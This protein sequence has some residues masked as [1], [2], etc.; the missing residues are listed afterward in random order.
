MRLQDFIRDSL[1][2]ISGGVQEARSKEE[3][4]APHIAANPPKD[5]A[6]LSADSSVIFLVDFD[7][8]VTVSEKSADGL[9]G[10]IS[11]ASVFKV[12]GKGGTSSEQSSISR[13]RFSVPVI[14]TRKNETNL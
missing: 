4:I 7:V 6:G 10:G 13:V 12:E 11:V 3:K 9:S 2:Q 1:L 8:A 5:S 14:F